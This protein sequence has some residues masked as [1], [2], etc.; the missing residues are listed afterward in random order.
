MAALMAA[1][2]SPA[3]QLP[4]GGQSDLERYSARLAVDLAKPQALIPL[5]E[6]YRLR[7]SVRDRGQVRGALNRAAESPK[8]NALV[9]AYAQFYLSQM[10]V[11][12]GDLAAAAGRRKR[13][14]AVT[15]WFVI[16]P[17]SNEGKAGFRYAFPPEKAFDTAA[18]YEG[19]RGPV[20]WRA[21]HGLFP[22]GDINLLDLFRPNLKVLAYAAAWLRVDEDATVVMRLAS[23]DAVKAWVNGGQVHA[24]NVYRPM[25]FDQDA[26]PVR[27]SKGWNLLL[28]KVTQ[29]EGGWEF[30]VRLTT[31]DGKPFTAFQTAATIEQAAKL[32]HAKPQKPGRVK[33]A[34]LR[35][36][37]DADAKARPRSAQAIGDLAWYDAMCM[38][39]DVKDQRAVAE[40]RRAAELAPWYPEFHYQL[41]RVQ[42]EPNLARQA[43]E[44]ALKLAPDFALARYMLGAHYSRRGMY[45]KAMKHAELALRDNPDFPEPYLLKAYVL[46]EHYAEPLA[47]KL[48]HE[49]QKRFPNST[50]LLERMASLDDALGRPD[51]AVALRRQELKVSHFNRDARLALAEEFRLRGQLDA[52][53]AQYQELLRVRPT[54]TPD[55]LNQ[56][57]ILRAAG[58]PAKAEALCRRALDICPD[59]DAAAA[60]LGHCLHEQ[61]KTADALKVWQRALELRP[62]NAKL[63]EYVEFLQPNAATFESEYVYD[64]Q[65]LIQRAPG[66]K[67]YPD[68]AKVLLVNLTVRRVHSNGLHSTFRQVVYKILTEKGMRDLQYFSVR[69]TPQEQRFQ[70]RR[71]RVIKPSG[72]RIAIAPPTQRGVRNDDLIYA[73]DAAMQFRIT[74]LAVGDVVELQYQIDDI[75][76]RNERAEYFGTLQYLQTT[77]PSVRTQ[78]VLISPKSKKLYYRTVGLDM[79]PR[80]YEKDDEIV[81][82]WQLDHVPAL[83]EEPRMPGMTEIV[84]YVHASTYDK[85]EDLARWYQ[86]LIQDQFKLGERGKKLAHKIV[87]GKKTERD[88]IVALYGYVSKYTRYLGLEFGIHGNKPYPAWQVLDRGY[89]D[90][91]DKATLFCSMLREVGV[92]ARYALLRTRSA[93]AVA[94]YPPS[95]YAFNHVIAY[96]PKFDWWLDCTTRF[97]GSQELPPMDQGAMALIVN[98]DGSCKLTTIPRA[99]AAANA[100]ENVYDVA[101]ADSGAATLKLR[102]KIIGRPA[103]SYRAR[104]AVKAKR[105]QIM[106]RQLGKTFP[107]A[108]VTKVAFTDVTHIEKPVQYACEATVPRFAE[109]RDGGLAFAHNPVGYKMV[110]SYAPLSERVHPVVLPYPWRSTLRTTVRLP[111]GYRVVSKMPDVNLR[112]PF[113]L[114]LRKT[115]VAGNTV[116]IEMTIELSVWRVEVNDYRAFRDFCAAVD[117]KLRDKVRIAKTK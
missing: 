33:A 116:K 16:G 12:A 61:G 60:L 101:L 97:S 36:A 15:D 92:D 71:C 63:K 52:C 27:L 25:T 46:S 80:I 53:V 72:E 67:R 54:Y 83:V 66:A 28:L 48:L 34:T 114:L 18:T 21:T 112:T 8:T 6:I 93:G 117:L 62:Q 13:L 58:Q 75:A 29:D 113:G 41:G 24:N 77:A 26:A 88:K 32:T 70:A 14:G 47:L 42:E 115:T 55:L 57:Q 30:R 89:G 82:V 68:A 38:S 103:A 59:D 94:P 105:R 19:K 98:P 5:T 56:A 65:E 109:R 50:A 35:D 96:V 17:F 51:L 86:G 44:R 79:K 87:A 81:H 20:R 95:L 64:V 78:F 39:A 31:P 76:A 40:Y 1:G 104:Y 107:G 37:F 85:W 23:D 43:L 111:R 100:Y 91:K 45:R 90:C 84:P 3:Q 74:N 69:F 102:R 7:F 73:N 106:E 10:D 49:Q 2:P 22:L 108:K 110:R 11:E 9:R 4:A 99:K